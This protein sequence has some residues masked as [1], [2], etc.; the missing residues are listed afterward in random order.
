MCVRLCIIDLGANCLVVVFI[1]GKFY[2]YFILLLFFNDTLVSSTRTL[3][4]D[5]F[6][7]K[8]KKPCS[9]G[10]IFLGPGENRNKIIDPKNDNPRK[11]SATEVN[12][13]PL[14][15]KLS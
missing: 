9:P 4:V 13:F 7:W 5:N 8:K 12:L 2:I 1:N 3:P 14:L 15:T 11:Y 10:T 6:T